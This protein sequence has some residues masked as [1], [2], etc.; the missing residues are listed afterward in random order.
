M[1][2]LLCIAG[3]YLLMIACVMNTKNLRSAIVFKVIPC[4]LG[5]FSLLAGVYETGIINLII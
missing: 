1:G 5:I 2:I 3:V 4:I